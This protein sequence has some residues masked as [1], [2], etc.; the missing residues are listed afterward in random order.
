MELTDV[1][2]TQVVS[3]APETR[4]GDAARRM[5]EFDVGAAVVLAPGDALVGVITER[6]LLRC[7]S[8]GTDPT[9]PVAD[10]MTRH[11]LTAAPGTELAEAMALMVDGRFRHLPIVNDEGRVIGLV[12]MRDLMAY[13]SLRLRGGNLGPDDDLDP[14]EVIATIHRMRTGAA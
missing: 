3:V 13:T 9:T 4:I 5:I 1:M 14:A 2:S 8:E 7:M 10:R 11:V 12:S 6:D